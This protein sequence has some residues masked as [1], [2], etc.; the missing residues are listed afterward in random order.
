VIVHEHLAGLGEPRKRE[1]TRRIPSRDDTRRDHSPRVIDPA[2]EA[3][4][5]AS[6]QP[7]GRANGGGSGV[8]EA[9]GRQ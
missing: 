4:L 8:G 7:D 9:R 1:H 3:D 2:N 6:S 5:A